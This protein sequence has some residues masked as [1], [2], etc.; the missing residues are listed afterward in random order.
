MKIS[1]AKTLLKA[2]VNHNIDMALQAERGKKVHDQFIVPFFIG[3]PGVGKTAI[4]RQ[5]AEDLEVMYRQT[6]V[7]Q[8]DAGEM[9]GLP[10]K[11]DVPIEFDEKGNVLETE[12]QMIRL[13][14]TYL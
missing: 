1:E 13:R 6:I 11:H 5:V 10:F 9:A 2:I 7:A 12:P 3:D 14:P 4:P 8:Y